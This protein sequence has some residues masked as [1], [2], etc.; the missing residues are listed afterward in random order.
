[1]EWFKLY[2]VC[3][4]MWGPEF[5]SQYRQ[6]I[7]RRSAWGPEW[8]HLCTWCAGFWNSLFSCRPSP[9]Q[10]LLSPQVFIQATPLQC[11]LT[12]PRS[13]QL[14]WFC[15]FIIS[16]TFTQHT[17]VHPLESAAPELTGVPLALAG[18][19]QVLSKTKNKN[20]PAMW[21][22]LTPVIPATQEAEI[23]KIVDSRDPVLKNLIAKKGWWSDWRCRL[24]VQTPVL[25]TQKKPPK[26]EDQGRPD[27]ILEG[28]GLLD[29]WRC[30]LSPSLRQ[31]RLETLRHGTQEPGLRISTVVRG[32]L[33]SPTAHLTIAA[34]YDL[35]L[36]LMVPP[37]S[38]WTHSE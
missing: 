30:A 8:L 34:G 9:G 33:N 20:P 19:Q 4:A 31:A 24:W 16:Y 17:I 10:L 36:A 22:W 38:G 5:K 26:C 3:L 29:F 25:H 12:C 18:T 14:A 23:R 1:V 27:C 11:C 2:S 21:W 7:L 6:K 15:S 35:N 13:G 37:S 28:V 32:K